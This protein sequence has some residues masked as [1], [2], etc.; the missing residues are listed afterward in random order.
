MAIKVRIKRSVLGKEVLASTYLPEG[1]T[2]N[3]ERRDKADLLDKELESATKAINSAYA[4]LSVEERKNDFLKWK[5]L[6]GELDKVVRKLLSDGTLEQSDIDAN[7]IWPGFAQY[8]RPE[9]FRGMDTRRSGST[10]D[11][12]RKCWQLANTPHTDWITT[13]TGWDA[14]VDRGAQLVG[15][16]KLM[17]ILERHLSGMR[18]GKEEYQNLARCIA[19][20]LPSIGQ[21]ASI[22]EMSEEYLEELIVRICNEL[23]LLD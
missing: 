12:Y 3:K 21:G 18:L 13:W 7:A 4:D 23:G 9:L 6:G 16:K 5:W 14:F 17:P 15:S 2:L 10:K 22:S 20:E 8:M 11:H 19:D 1:Q